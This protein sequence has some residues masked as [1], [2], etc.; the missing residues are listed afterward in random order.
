MHISVPCLQAPDSLR[1]TRARSPPA[2]P[3]ACRCTTQDQIDRIKTDTAKIAKQLNITGPFNTQF[4]CKD[5]WI[6]VIETNL[7]ASRSVPFVS[8]CLGRN[9]IDIAARCLVG[10][11]VDDQ[12]DSTTQDLSH[13]LVKS[14]QF[15][16]PRLP[17]ADPLLGVEMSSTGEVA[18]FGKTSEEAYLKSIIASG[19]RMPDRSKPVLVIATPEDATQHVRLCVGVCVRWS[20][21]ARVCVVHVCVCVVHVCVCVVHV[22]L[23]VLR[24]VGSV[25]VE[26]DD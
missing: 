16:F 2:R 1:S 15:S 8:K 26:S 5:D 10:Q 7:R 25:G 20:A 14:P 19:F 17:G 9:F 22:C 4:L 21:S 13:V 24:V 6:G 18:C 23:C 11:Q 12:V 3:P